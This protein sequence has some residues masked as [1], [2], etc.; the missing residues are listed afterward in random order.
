[1]IFFDK[2]V[3]IYIEQD[4]KIDLILSPSFYWVKK[5][6]LPIKNKNEV[7]KLLPSLF[8]DF[9]PEGEYS[10]YFCQKDDEI[11]AFAYDDSFILEQ[12]NKKA[13]PLSK[14]NSVRFAQCE[15]SD[16]YLPYKI[17]EKSALIKQDDIVIK[18][19]I[20][21]VLEYKKELPPSKE[22]SKD[23]I[24]LEQFSKIIDSKSIYM[25]SGIL[26]VFILIYGFSWYLTLNQTKKLQDQVGAIYKKYD[27]LSTSFQNKSLYKKYKKIDKKQKLLKEILSKVV[28]IRFSKGE[29]IDEIKLQK[30]KL[31]ITFKGITNKQ[32][33]LDVIKKFE[34]L[35][36][37]YKDKILTVEI[38]I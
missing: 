35:D 6:K 23:K 4:K 14:I 5:F 19:P 34:V 18:I 13:I 20:E 26:A 16:K 27:L 36:T 25:L 17:D 28:K 33:V 30:D 8:D 32:K 15:F 3:D 12:I 21:F 2:N 22:L 1:V 7:K 24:S 10:Y 31:Y 38:K 9:L 11:I 37:K 29:F